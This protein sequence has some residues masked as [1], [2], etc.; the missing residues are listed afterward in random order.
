MG[1][2][3]MDKNQIPREGEIYKVVQVGDKTFEIVYGYYSEEERQWG[4]AMPILPDFTKTPMYTIDGEP[5]I[6]RIQ[7][8]CEYYE[9]PDDKEGD[10]WC[11]DC[12]HNSSPKDEIS[13]CRCERNRKNGGKR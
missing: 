2:E 1:G 6:T 11:A 13:V 7:D 12:R 9:V 5:L 8:S 10:G 3:G 4:E